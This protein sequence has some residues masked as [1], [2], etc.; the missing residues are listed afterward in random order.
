MTQEDSS[1]KPNISEQEV[2]SIVLQLI[3]GHSNDVQVEEKTFLDLL[4]HSLSL[5]TVEKKRVIDAVPNLSQFQ[6]DELAKVFI[7]ERE[8]FKELSKEHP[9]D[10]KKLLKKQQIEWLQLGDIYKSELA[11]KSKEDAD[12]QK[13]DEIKKSL[14]L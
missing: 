2:D 4:K 9:D 3:E 13:A 7:E 8:K 14:G 10:I 5:S 1:I 11:N 6:F 12:K